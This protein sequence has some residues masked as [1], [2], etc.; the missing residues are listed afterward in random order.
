MGNNPTA[1][2]VPTN[3]VPQNR[4]GCQ[5]CQNRRHACQQH[6]QLQQQLRN[7]PAFQQFLPQMQ[8]ACSFSSPLMP[9]LQRPMGLASCSQT[10]FGGAADTL[11]NAQQCFGSSPMVSPISC[12]LVRPPTLSPL[13]YSPSSRPMCFQTPQQSLSPMSMMM[14]PRF[15]CGGGIGAQQSMIGQQRLFGPPCQP[16][17]GMRPM[18]QLGLGQDSQSCFSCLKGTTRSPTQQ[19]LTV[20]L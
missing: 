15:M 10:S 18:Q 17:M 1:D 3:M 2:I 8:Q 9:P 19:F 4:C 7:S 16:Q 11:D 6:Q 5:C 12:P 20:D 14:R 13:S